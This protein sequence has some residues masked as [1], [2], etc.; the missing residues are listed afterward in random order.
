MAPT[1]LNRASFAGFVGHELDICTDYESLA[2]LGKLRA[3][4][5]AKPELVPLTKSCAEQFPDR[6]VLATCAVTKVDPAGTLKTALRY[7]NVDT[8]HD[9]DAES[10]L[11]AHGDW[12]PNTDKWAVQHERTKRQLQQLRKLAEHPAP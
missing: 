10:C 6:T 11:R 4:L 5:G 2:S 3:E 1:I 7:Y 12:Q 9:G 8:V